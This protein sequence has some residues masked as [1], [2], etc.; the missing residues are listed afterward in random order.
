MRLHTSLLAVLLL[1]AS[2]V[3]AAD[4]PAAAP[5]AAAERAANVQVIAYY[6]HGTVRCETCLKI[7]QQTREAIERRFPVEAAAK[8]LVFKPVNYDK[9]ENA[10]FLKDYKL[11]SPSLV[12]V[13]QKG[14]KDERWKLLDEIW[15]Y[16][17]NP[18][19]FNEYVKGEVNK[20]LQ[21]EK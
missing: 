19:A 12:V 9:L 8:R 1:A 5:P 6:F 3:V 16:V 11:Q 18:L 15:E 4:K 14:G 21:E 13:R 20:F 7:E 10:H 2:V 17:R